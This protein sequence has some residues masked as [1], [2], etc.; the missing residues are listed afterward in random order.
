MAQ[1]TTIAVHVVVAL[2]DIVNQGIVPV[3]AALG[4]GQDTRS[5]LYWGAPYGIRTHLTRNAGWTAATDLRPRDPRILERRVFRA[6]LRRDGRIVPVYLIAIPASIGGI[7]T[8]RKQLPPA[9]HPS[10]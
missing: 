5:N 2:C 7:S 6:D 8:N 4:N 9:P 1:G 10:A 3:P